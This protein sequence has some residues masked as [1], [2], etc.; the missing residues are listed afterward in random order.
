MKRIVCPRIPF[1]AS[2]LARYLTTPNGAL[3]DTEKPESFFGGGALSSALDP[4]ILFSSYS[5]FW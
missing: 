4:P 5:A 3:P 2:P 1:F